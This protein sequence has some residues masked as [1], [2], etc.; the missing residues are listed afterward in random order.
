MDLLVSLAAKAD[1]RTCELRPTNGN[2]PEQRR[3]LNRPQGIT[4]ARRGKAAGTGA[5][6]KRR[7]TDG[8]QEDGTDPFA[9]AERRESLGQRAGENDLSVLRNVRVREVE[10]TGADHELVAQDEAD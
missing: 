10:S 5:R 3:V 9:P 6:L 2:C 7:T 8:A 1:T 4:S